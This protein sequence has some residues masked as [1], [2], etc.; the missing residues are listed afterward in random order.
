MSKKI[1][2]KSMI[3]LKE[4]KIK[5][6]RKKKTRQACELGPSGPACLGL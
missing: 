1:K 5:G 6:L 4:N 3:K 2:K